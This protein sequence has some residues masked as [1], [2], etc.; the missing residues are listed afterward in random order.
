MRCVNVCTCSLVAGSFAHLDSHTEKCARSHGLE[1]YAQ[2]EH[3][4]PGILDA[5]AETYHTPCVE[6]RVAA[7]WFAVCGGGVA[8]HAHPAAVLMVPQADGEGA[9]ASHDEPAASGDRAE[10]LVASWGVDLSDSDGAIPGEP[11]S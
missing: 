5:I 9:A 6:D 7:F 10:A 4:A 11:G 1:C 2:T 8:A 3:C